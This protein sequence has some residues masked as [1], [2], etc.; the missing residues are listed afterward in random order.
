M[1][2]FR[3]ILFLFILFVL[4]ENCTA[5]GFEIL[6]QTHTIRGQI[7]QEVGYNQS[8]SMPLSN[9]FTNSNGS[10]VSSETGIGSAGNFAAFECSA[11]ASV[12]W[13]DQQLNIEAD[14]RASYTLVFQPRGD[15][16]EIHHILGG[17]VSV[18]AE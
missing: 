12:E 7:G 18:P 4:T 16:I 17:C 1:A 9:N 5:D 15:L 11:G 2:Q 6:S 3:L 14:A 8:N 13:P 10:R